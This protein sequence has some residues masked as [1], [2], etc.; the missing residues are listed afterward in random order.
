MTEDELIELEYSYTDWWGSCRD[1]AVSP[2]L[3]DLRYCRRPKDHAG[4]CSSGR[5]NEQ[6]RWT[7]KAAS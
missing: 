1:T 5:G 7:R 2:D 4:Q 6:V 3:R